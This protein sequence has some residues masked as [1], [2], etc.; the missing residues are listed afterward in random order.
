MTERVRRDYLKSISELSG[1]ARILGSMHWPSV[2]VCVTSTPKDAWLTDFSM[3]ALKRG[4]PSSP[5]G[6]S[7]ASQGLPE[8]AVC[9]RLQSIV[10]PERSADG[11]AGELAYFRQA[12]HSRFDG[13]NS[14]GEAVAALLDAESGTAGHNHTYGR[15][16][17]KRFELRRPFLQIL[18]FVKKHI[19]RQALLCALIQG[20]VEYRLLIPVNDPQYRLR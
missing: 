9:Q 16:V 1:S 10:F 15:A 7:V 8:I 5:V 2:S 13:C 11:C 6:H 14:S 4:V 12:E 19:C 20:G 17:N 18:H 3:N